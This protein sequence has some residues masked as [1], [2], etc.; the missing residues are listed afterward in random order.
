M[1][2]HGNLRRFRQKVVL[3]VLWSAVLL[4]TNGM[5]T[6]CSKATGPYFRPVDV[7]DESKAIIYVY[8]PEQSVGAPLSYSIFANGYFVTKLDNG[9]YYPFIVVPGRVTLSFTEHS[10]LTAPAPSHRED[11]PHYWSGGF[12]ATLDVEAGKTYF[13]K[14]WLREKINPFKASAD[15]LLLPVFDDEQALDEIQTCRLMEP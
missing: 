11:V 15:L 14:L 2:K 13:V 5:S 1:E 6:G 8:R 3:Y 12:V 4:F 9:G 7:V 10:S